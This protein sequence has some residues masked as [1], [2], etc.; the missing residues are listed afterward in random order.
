MLFLSG[1]S[2]TWTGPAPEQWWHS[3]ADV[4]GSANCGGN[5]QYQRALVHCFIGKQPIRLPLYDRV[6]LTGSGFDPQAIQYNDMAT[7]VLD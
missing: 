3:H 6:T 2:Q 4:P 5:L 7:A 1:A